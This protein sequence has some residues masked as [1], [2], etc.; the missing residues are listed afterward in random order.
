M[1]FQKRQLGGAA[2]GLVTLEKLTVAL[3]V[4]CLLG[5]A[6]GT[7]AQSPSLYQCETGSLTKAIKWASSGVEEVFVD[8]MGAVP[9]GA[10]L[11]LDALRNQVLRVGADGRV[12]ELDLGGDLG[13]LRQIR[14]ARDGGYLVLSLNQS[15]RPEVFH[16]SASDPSEARLVVHEDPRIFMMYNFVAFGSGV[17]AFGDVDFGQGPGGQFGQATG[18][19]SL[20]EDGEIEFLHTLTDTSSSTS[21][22]YNYTTDDSARYLAST[23]EGDLGFVLHLD[24]EPS[25]ERF[26]CDSGESIHFDVPE[27]FRYFPRV[28]ASQ[29][30]REVGG[31]GVGVVTAYHKV[32]ERQRRVA[33]GIHVDPRGNLIFIG[34]SQ[35][36]FE[37]EARWT[38]VHLD[39]ETGRELGRIDL[40]SSASHLVAVPGAAS[41]TLIEKEAV[42]ARFVD[43][44]IGEIPYLKTATMTRVPSQWFVDVGRLGFAGGAAGDSSSCS[45]LP[46]R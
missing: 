6:T 41:W 34:R 7:A 40:P 35:M 14:R 12:R 39:R 45:F 27:D 42:K 17:L 20:D 22:L 9:T 43:D 15:K 29:A 4:V 30:W 38:A 32:L 33:S 5:A 13:Y 24:L 8:E 36:G 37:G 3:A 25:I 28:A 31:R 26:D 21:I 16:V 44:R 19:F 10:S 11:V 1:K 2:N 23:P 18:F 46:S